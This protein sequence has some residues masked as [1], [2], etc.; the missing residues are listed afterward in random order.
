MT[1]LHGIFGKRIGDLREWI[2]G[3]ENFLE[4]NPATWRQAI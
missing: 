2:G 1:G 4:G 3:F